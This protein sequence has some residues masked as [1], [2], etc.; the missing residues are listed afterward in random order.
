ME[1]VEICAA[2]EGSLLNLQRESYKIGDTAVLF[3]CWKLVVYTQDKESS[4]AGNTANPQLHYFGHS[5]VGT[6]KFNFLFI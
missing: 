1:L 4:A 5:E 3:S 2:E 6:N